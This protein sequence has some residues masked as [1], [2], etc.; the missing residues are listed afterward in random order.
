[1]EGWIKLHRKLIT[2]EWYKYPNAVHVFIY[3]L[4]SANT[5]NKKWKGIDIQRGEF[6]TSIRKMAANTG[7]S[8]QSVRTCLANLQS[9]QELTIKS[10]HHYSLIT[11]NK[12]EDYQINKNNINTEINTPIT[13]NLTHDQQQHKNNKEER[14]LKEINNKENGT[15]KID[16]KKEEEVDNWNKNLL[17]DERY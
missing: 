12:Y 15:I 3:L 7:V 14:I 13:H 2:W 8:I 10:T 16:P 11:I 17:S 5:A 1:M 6:L 9:T 4:L